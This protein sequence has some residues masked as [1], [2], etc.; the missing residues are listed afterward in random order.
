MQLGE[1]KQ[2][3]STH[4]SLCDLQVHV[5]TRRLSGHMC[6]SELR[7][8]FPAGFRCQSIGC[9]TK[10]AWIG[11]VAAS[12][13][14]KRVVVASRGRSITRRHAGARSSNLDHMVEV[15]GEAIAPIDVKRMEHQLG[16][17]TEYMQLPVRQY[18]LIQMP[19]NASLERIG[20]RA[21]LE[22]DQ[23]VDVFE[24]IVPPVRF[25]GLFTVRPVVVC[26]VLPQPAMVVIESNECSINGKDAEE[27]DLNSLFDF[28]VRTEITWIDAPIR[29]EIRCK[30]LLAVRVDPPRFIRVLFPRRM[31]EAI[32]RLAIGVVLGVLQKQFIKSLVADYGKWAVDKAYRDDRERWCSEAQ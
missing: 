9:V 26:T 13:R 16:N 7:L 17:L 22:S 20:S 18:A 2:V 32:G 4:L 6:C 3:V 28:A 29:K 23:Q 21:S 10:S 25:P 30:S 12:L 8:C 24:L 27:F 19:L 14:V 11:L 15:H 5:E 1:P 31:L